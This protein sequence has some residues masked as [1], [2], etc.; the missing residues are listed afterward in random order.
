MHLP[1][2]P[3]HAT[4]IALSASRKG[5]PWAGAERH[6]LIARDGTFVTGREARRIE[7]FRIL[8]ALAMSMDGVDQYDDGCPSLDVVR[9]ETRS[10]HRLTRQHRDRWVDAHAFLDDLTGQHE[11]VYVGG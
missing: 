5:F 2:V 9:P 11:L 10:S 6:V 1:Y 3:W 4:S 7:E 8:P